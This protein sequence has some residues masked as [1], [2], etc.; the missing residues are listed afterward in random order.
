MTKLRIAFLA[1]FAIFAL[2]ACGGSSKPQAHGS[3]PTPQLTSL[4]AP[5]Y[6]VS[7]KPS[8][9]PTERPPGHEGETE[10]EHAEHENDPNTISGKY[11]PDRPP[12]S[13]FR[14]SDAGE[15]VTGRGA[16]PFEMKIDPGCAVPGQIVEVTLRTAPD[17]SF[18]MQSSIP[19][20]EENERSA[21]AIGRTDHRGLYLWKLKIP[22]NMQPGTYDVLAAVADDKGDR[23][24]KSGHWLFVVA[25]P[26]DCSS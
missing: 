8:A 15:G 17:L 12:P 20:S 25:H 11:A 26:G 1:A 5:S 16:M 21:K 6:S 13:E 14:R 24:G 7:V 22:A 23:G 10:E 2:G 3:G 4:P 9:K 18:G 19:E